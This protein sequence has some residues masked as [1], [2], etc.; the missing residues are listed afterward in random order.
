MERRLRAVVVNAEVERYAV[1]NQLLPSFHNE[2]AA[3]VGV[4]IDRGRSRG[5]AVFV[6]DV[7]VARVDE[8]RLEEPAVD[9]QAHRVFGI[10]FNAG[11]LLRDRRDAFEGRGDLGDAGRLKSVLVV[12][13]DR[14]RRVEGQAH[15]LAV[16]GVVVAHRAFD[17]VQ[18]HEGILLEQIGEG[19]YPIHIRQIG[20]RH[21]E[22]LEHVRAF[23][24][25][26]RSLNLDQ[27][28]VVS[29]LILS[30]DENFVLRSVERIDVRLNRFADRAAM[31]CQNVTVRFCVS[32]L[33]MD[34][35]PIVRTRARTRVRN[36]FI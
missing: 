24:R 15:E 33:A 22:H 36:L 3:A 13:H 12:V 16:H 18:A 34:A 19:H 9:G 25:G 4:V 17:V 35:K 31:Q 30:V 8:H 14:G 32:A 27:G 23:A 10:A 7:V 1:V 28:V 2:L 29:A 5:A 26:N 11:E 20:G 21:F 6:V